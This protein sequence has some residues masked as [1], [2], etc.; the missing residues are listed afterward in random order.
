[1]NGRESPIVLPYNNKENGGMP[2]FLGKVNAS[3]GAY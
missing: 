3:K 1:M 2:W